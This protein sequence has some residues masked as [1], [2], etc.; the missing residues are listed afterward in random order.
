MKVLVMIEGAGADEA[1]IEPTTEMFEQMGRY[2]EE[3]VQAGIMLG[4]EGLLPSARGARVVF[5]GGTTS[6]VDGPFVEAKELIAGYWI[7]EVSSLEEA[8]EWAKRCPANQ[9][10]PRAV[11]E[12]RPIASIEDFGDAYTPEVAAAEEKLA[13]QIKAQHG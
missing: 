8:V 9:S 1:K 4:G 2:N 5:E 12:I 6:V 13:E 11:L 3:L 7:W 10:G